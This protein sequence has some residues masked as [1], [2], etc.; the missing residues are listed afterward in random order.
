LDDGAIL[1]FELDR[2]LALAGELEVGGAVLVA[3]GMTPDDDRLRP[4]RHQPRD[5]L[6]DD[7][8]AE[9]DA[10]ED[11]TDGAVRRLPHLLEAEFL[12]PRF[13]RR[14]GGA[15]YADAVLLDG[16]RR[17]DRDL[18]VG[19]VPVLDAEVV[20]LE[21]HI[22]V[23]VDELLLDELP[24][25]ASHLVAVELDDGSCHLDFLHIALTRSRGLLTTWRAR[26]D[27]RRPSPGVIDGSARES[28]WPGAGRPKLNQIF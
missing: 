27:R 4:A 26:P 1:S 22:K 17:V 6:A 12:H 23:G 9:D 21:I 10:A 5:V 28:K 15:F 7:G 11:V 14:D 16:V 8:L 13:I 19:A 20:V 24:D 2:Q 18:V 25:D 3:E